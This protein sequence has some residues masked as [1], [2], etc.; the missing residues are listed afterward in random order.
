[1]T[2]RL[3]QPVSDNHVVRRFR[4]LLSRVDI[5]LLVFCVIFSLPIC[6]PSA[7]EVKA[8]SNHS[9]QVSKEKC[10]DPVPALEKCFDPR[11]GER[12]SSESC[13]GIVG[14]YWCKNDKDNVPLKE[15]YCG[16][17]EECFRG[18]EGTT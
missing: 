17:S 4:T 6:P 12:N 9:P 1:M 3:F 10:T 7:P 5:T 8:T 16:S 18:R 15:P 2:I 11:C 14:C 13:E